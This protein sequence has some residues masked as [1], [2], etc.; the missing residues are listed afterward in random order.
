M[1]LMDPQEALEGGFSQWL[2]DVAGGRYVKQAHQLDPYTT[3]WRI[4]GQGVPWLKAIET[5]SQPQTADPGQNVR[6]LRS[7]GLVEGGGNVQPTLTSLGAATLTAWRHL[8][9]DNS[10][11]RDEVAR[12]ATIVRC[13]LDLGE[14]L[15]VRMFEFWCEL[16]GLRPAADWFGDIPGLYLAS[17]LNYTSPSG[18]NPYRVLV[19]LDHDFAGALPSWSTWAQSAGDPHLTRLVKAVTDFSNRPGGRRTFCQGMEAVR[20]TRSGVDDLPGLIADW[21]LPA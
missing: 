14:T 11:T 15:Y 5:G 12:A 10:D 6:D 1:S 19:A 18:Y 20:L 8:G 13:A 2:N 16:L 21:G 7:A 17:Y 4:S 9:V 3:S